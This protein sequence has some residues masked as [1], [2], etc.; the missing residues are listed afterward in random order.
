MT[1]VAGVREFPAF[2][3]NTQSTWRGVSLVVTARDGTA[4]NGIYAVVTQD[5]AELRV[6]L[7]GGA[8]GAYLTSA[9]ARAPLPSFRSRSASQRYGCG[10]GAQDVRAPVGD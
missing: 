4:G 3:F 5:P 7:S 10:K 9:R 2:E 6:T 8:S 1:R